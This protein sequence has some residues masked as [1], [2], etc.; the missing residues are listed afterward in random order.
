MSKLFKKSHEYKQKKVH[1]DPDESSSNRNK[2]FLMI[3]RLSVT[4]KII[5]IKKYQN[6]IREA[7]KNNYFI[8]MES[9][10]SEEELSTLFKSFIKFCEELDFGY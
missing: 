4:D 3:E 6:F 5:K 9:D 7:E 10:S 1:F 8:N 2:R